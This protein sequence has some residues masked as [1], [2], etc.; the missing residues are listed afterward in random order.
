MSRYARFSDSV[1][2]GG[3]RNTRRYRTRISQR[4]VRPAQFLGNRYHQSGSKPLPDVRSGPMISGRGFMP[5][6]GELREIQRT[7]VHDFL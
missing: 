2:I 3:H 5:T 7:P 6:P 1:G 4:I